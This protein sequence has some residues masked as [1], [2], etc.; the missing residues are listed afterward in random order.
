VGDGRDA[1]GGRILGCAMF[2]TSL[3]SK[4][5]QTTGR[6]EK[7]RNIVEPEKRGTGRNLENI[8]GDQKPWW[9]VEFRKAQQYVKLWL[10]GIRTT[11]R[12]GVVL[13]A[14]GHDDVISQR[15]DRDGGGGGQKERRTFWEEG[16]RTIRKKQRLQSTNQ[17]SH[18]KV[19][20]GLNKRRSTETGGQYFIEVDNIDMG[21]G[22]K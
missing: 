5:G 22:K 11:A 21:K 15:Q 6:R 1:L 19:A 2:G 13:G 8:R 9:Y 10:E 7:G 3:N 4:R 12:V 17:H 18:I 16:R 20:P 14:H